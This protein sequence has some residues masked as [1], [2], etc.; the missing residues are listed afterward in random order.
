MVWW[1]NWHM[2]Q[3]KRWTTAGLL[4]Q[5]FNPA[6]LSL[7]QTDCYRSFHYVFKQQIAL[8]VGAR[9]VRKINSHV[10]PAIT[11]LLS[12]VQIIEDSWETEEWVAIVGDNVEKRRDCSLVKKLWVWHWP[13][14]VHSLK[15]MVMWCDRENLRLLEPFRA[16]RMYRRR[17]EK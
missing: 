6:T 17:S 3:C 2:E 13:D 7:R 8:Q 1:L 14:P 4:D 15:L 9:D 12:Y 11:L 5:P 10:Q 16:M